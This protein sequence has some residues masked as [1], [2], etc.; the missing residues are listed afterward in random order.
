MIWTRP[1]PGSAAAGSRSARQCRSAAAA[2]PSCT[3]RPE[4]ELSSSRQPR[5]GQPGPEHHEASRARCGR[6]ATDRPAERALVR[7]AVYRGRCDI[8]IEDV[9]EPVP[10]AGELLLRVAA[11]GICG[12]DGHEYARGPSQFAVPS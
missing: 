8:R 3:T 9:A 6:A 1:S 4:T 7:A 5:T 10:A 11:T 2:S 12:T